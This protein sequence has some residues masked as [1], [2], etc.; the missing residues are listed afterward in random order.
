[1]WAIL[2]LC[3]LTGKSQEA[4][5]SLSEKDSLSYEKVKSAILRV[6]ELV[7][8]AYWQRFHNLR[9]TSATHA[10][11]AR[12]KGMLFDCWCSACRADNLI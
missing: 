2:L 1:M 3:K 10:D 9:K 11:F 8:K 7:P 5:S 6:Y 4:C 12:D